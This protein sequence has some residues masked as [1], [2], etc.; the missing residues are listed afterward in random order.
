MDRVAGM[1]LDHLR[2]LHAGAIDVTPVVPRFVHR[3]TAVGIR[4][5]GSRFT[6][7]RMLNRFWDYPRH[8][9]RLSQ[10]FDIFHVI[11]HSY[12]QLVH[13]LP[14]HRTVVTCHDLDTFRSILNPA[15]EQ[16]S[17]PFMAM[18]RHVLGGMQRAARV[19]CD[20]TVVRNE[21]IARALIP[22]ARLVVASVGAGDVYSSRPDAEGDREAGRLV[23]APAGACEILHVGSTIPRKRIDLL[24]RICGA[25]VAE[26]PALHLVRVGGPLSPEQRQ[27]A[28]AVGM[29]GRMSELEFVD[30]RTLAAIYRRAALVLLPSDREGFGLP[31]VEAMA[32]GTPVVASDLPALREVGGS[33]AEYCARDSATPWVQRVLELLDERQHAP[34]VWT[35]RRNGGLER[36]GRFTWPAF[37]ARLARVYREVAAEADPVLARKPA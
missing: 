24:L 37:A 32:C 1:L 25:L 7:D 17:K 13:H 19:T 20:T 36:A 29:D 6:I 34:S 3:A 9:G 18:V 16:R 23:H 33:A 22:P 21:L 31:I 11:D 15:D 12:S 30:D 14:P 2:R 35:E 5:A 8:V 4:S 26:V 27:I 28:R 10:D